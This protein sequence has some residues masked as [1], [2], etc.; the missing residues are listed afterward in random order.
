M[1]IMMVHAKQGCL[2]LYAKNF[3]SWGPAE[4]KTFGLLKRRVWVCNQKIPS[5][6]V[7]HDLLEPTSAFELSFTNLMKC[8]QNRELTMK[9]INM[10]IIKK[11]V[12]ADQ[13]LQELKFWTL[14]LS[15]TNDNQTNQK[16]TKLI[17][18]LK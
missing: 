3:F 14:F 2:N 8:I 13:L 5:A 10:I 15:D 16:F 4:M 18:V 7:S 1:M 12:S 6:V 11:D 9:T 17:W